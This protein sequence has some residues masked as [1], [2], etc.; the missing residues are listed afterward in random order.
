MSLGFTNLRWATVVDSEGRLLLF[1]NMRIAEEIRL[2]LGSL[3]GGCLTGPVVLR[4]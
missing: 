2:D 4:K 1:L 3:T